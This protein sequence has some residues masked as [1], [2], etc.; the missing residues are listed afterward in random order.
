[1]SFGGVG[2]HLGADAG[3][4]VLAETARIIRHGWHGHRGGRCGGCK[5]RR[6]VPGDL[7]RKVYFCGFGLGFR[8]R[9]ITGTF[10]IGSGGRRVRAFVGGGRCV[11]ENITRFQGLSDAFAMRVFGA[12]AAGHG[13]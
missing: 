8:I 1:M 10:T 11:R 12:F 3:G 13:G 5:G 7:S 2:G 6:L 4:A 9:S